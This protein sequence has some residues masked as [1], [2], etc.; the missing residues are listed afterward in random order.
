[1]NSISTKQEVIQTKMHLPVILSVNQKVYQKPYQQ[2]YEKETT[3]YNNSQGHI[4]HIVRPE[5]KWA[6]QHNSEA[7]FFFI[8]TCH[9]K[10][11]DTTTY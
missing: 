7:F 3:L 6:K 4:D 5:M 8:F 10:K 11:A 9:F 2:A 1:M